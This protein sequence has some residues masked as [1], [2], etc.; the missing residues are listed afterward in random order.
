MVFHPNITSSDPIDAATALA[1]LA[2]DKSRRQQTRK[3]GSI[4]IH[5]ADGS[6]T[7]VGTDAGRS[8][9]AQWVGD[10][11]P[12]GRPTGL[13]AS[14]VAGGVIVNWDGTLEKGIPADF[15]H[16]KITAKDCNGVIYDFGELSR[17]GSQSK[18]DMQDGTR[19][20]ITA[21][22]FDDAHNDKGESAPNVSEESE[23]IMVTVIGAVN[24]ADIDAVQ[25]NAQKALDTASQARLTADQ[26]NKIFSG[27]TPPDTSL[28]A[29]GD[30][31]FKIASVQNG[32][33]TGI[34]VWNGADWNDMVL[35]ANKVLVASSVGTTEIADN[36]I[37][38][39]KIMANAVTALQ[40]AAQSVTA[41]KVN[42]GDVTA[43]IVSSGRFTTPDGLTGFDANGFFVK[44]KDEK[45]LFT[46]NANGVNA[47]GG[48]QTSQNGTYMAMRQ[49]DI[50]SN[51]TGGISLI[52]KRN[53][54]KEIIHWG[55]SGN[56]S[57]DR[58]VKEFFVC[59]GQHRVITAR[60]SP[61]EESVTIGVNG[62]SFIQVDSNHGV[63]ING[64]PAD[65]ISIGQAYNSVNDDGP[66]EVTFKEVRTINGASQYSLKNGFLQVPLAGV[67]EISGIA[68]VFRQ[69][70]PEIIIAASRAKNN[71]NGYD[72]IPTNIYAR[73]EGS[74]VEFPVPPHFA[75]L[76]A[77]DCIGWRIESPNFT[78]MNGLRSSITAKLICAR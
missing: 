25:K 43:A 33:V 76:E 32:N 6:R 19:L 65:R 35:M 36:A 39:G 51:H 8:G 12:P 48:F 54:G 30:L 71:F 9:V 70:E 24:K 49:A 10:T 34:Y 78:A 44:S 41:D 11:T 63:T 47:V 26:K 52:E 42:V 72:R 74:W 62:G 75:Y 31:W 46:A 27:V 22:A 59:M 16:I 5:N 60:D 4:T 45:E 56:I 17:S 77:G 55:I 50:L 66:W 67:Y 18:A 21:V 23:P 58:T 7:I 20:T 57:D 38:T 64:A 53:D 68:N 2:L 13:T 69:G 15:S 37:T 3:A 1:Q 73:C 29:D 28:V 61:H 40:I 14:S